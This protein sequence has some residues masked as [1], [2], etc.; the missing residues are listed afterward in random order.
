M[1]EDLK[2]KALLTLGGGIRLPEGFVMPCRVSRSTAGPGA[3]MGSAAFSFDGYRVK[4]SISYDSGEFELH[5]DADGHLSLTHGG[6]PFIDD[7]VIEPIVRHCPEQAFFNIDP[8]CMFHCRFCSSPLLGMDD[9]KHMTTERMMEMLDESVRTQDVRAVSFTSGVVGSVEET[10]DRFIDV[11]RET[12]SRYP[13]MPIG[14]EPYVSSREDIQ[15][16]KDAG[17]DE[18]KLNLE[19]PNREI[20]GKVC[21]DLDMDSII[22]NLGH[23]VE[24]FGRGRVISNILYGLG[25]SDDDLREAMEMLCGMGVIPGLRALRV[26]DI[27]RESLR[28]SLGYVPEAVSTE[29]AIKLASMQKEIMKKHGLTSKTSNTMCMACR[30]CDIVPFRDF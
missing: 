21:P 9:D 7:I 20:F 16:L 5:E 26:N 14:V 30:C 19:T 2:K 10:L 17:A 25:E 11:I 3:G 28:S 29:R 18:I 4:K 22:S 1:E 23:A 27:N 8:R 6:E 15:S 13:D 12:R 24:I